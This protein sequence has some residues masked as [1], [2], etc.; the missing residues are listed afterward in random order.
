M[1]RSFQCSR[2]ASLGFTLIELMVT[3]AIVAILSA[4]AYPAYTDYVTRGRLV[5]A[6]NAVQN[7]Q[8]RLEQ[9][10]QDNRTYKSV[11]SSIVSP[12]ASSSTSGTFTVSCTLDVGTYTITATGSGLTNG[13]IYTVDNTNSKTST[14]SS[15]WGGSSYACWIMRKGDSCS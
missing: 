13:F 12:C 14:V 10:Y 3:V 2:A 9:Y 11:S 4:I 15:T 7:M 1:P 8:T 5:D 6:T